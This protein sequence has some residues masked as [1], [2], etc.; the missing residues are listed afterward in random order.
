MHTRFTS[1]S[2]ALII[3]LISIPIFV[4]ALDLTVVS[5]VL[6]RVVTDLE[7]PA[8]RLNDA[9]WIVSGYLLA[10]TVAM[11]F[12]GRLSD[13]IGRRKVY[14]LAL[15]IFALGSYWVAV[16]D[17][18][19]MQIALR[20]CYQFQIYPDP[21]RVALVT[22]IIGRVI[23]AFGGGAMVPVGMALAGDLYPAAQRA[24]ALGIIAAVDTSGWVVGHLYGGILTRFF[25]WHLI[26]WLNL[27]I[28]LLAFVLI[29]VVL[30]GLPRTSGE[31]K[32]D[33]LG[34][35]LISLSLTALNIG[36]G[37]SS[38]ETGTISGS[39]GDWLQRA[40]PFLAA[41]LVFLFLFL[42][43]Q[44]RLP[45]P[46]IQLP[47]FRRPNFSPATLANFLIG[48]SLFIAIANVPLFINTLVAK[49]LEQGAWDSGW[50]LSGLTVPMALASIPSGWL[51]VRYG[52]RR[53]ALVGLLL[54]IGGFALMSR[55]QMTTS[56]AAMTPELILTGI[57]LGLT[58]APIA[59]A[60]INT[61]P[62]QYRG[63]ASALVII[64][65]LLGMLVSVSTDA[66]YGTQRFNYL[67]AKFLTTMNDLTQAGMAATE[68]VI[69]ETFIM[70]AIV[71]ILALIPVCVLK[72]LPSERSVE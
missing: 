72:S 56:Y 32:M 5:A 53:P 41:A 24:K 64:F 12:M 60:A 14:L 35:V 45:Y 18:W 55:W 54:A 39:A 17:G 46:L 7:I 51:T 71:C 23:Q 58:M 65:R 49:D 29:A 3:A 40:W 10:Y 62:T 66:T 31:G 11:T 19:P 68:K 15:V 67:S 28:C 57:G 6:P 34:A 27:P 9:A 50:M 38:Q 48:T 52:Y 1:P 43:R 42:W 44:V 59:A 16:A 26:F 25:N 21:P 70:A 8:T 33:W 47:L 22:L 61:S 13:L 37:G 63:T 4:G 2:R 69:Q 20:I 30:R 36:V